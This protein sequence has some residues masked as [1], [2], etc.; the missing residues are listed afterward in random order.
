M[1]DTHCHLLPMCDDGADSWQ[2][3]LNMAREAVSIGIDTII[4]TPHHGKQ[5]YYNPPDKI[6]SAVLRCNRIFREEAI[7]L[8]VLAGQELH[9]N[10]R[11]EK[12]VD[13][14]QTLGHSGYVLLELPTKL[15]P[16]SLSKDLARLRAKGLQAIIAHPERHLPFVQ[17]P[18][19][20]YAYLR[21]GAYAQLTAAS[22]LG[23][24]GNAIQRAAWTMAR[25]GWIHLL[26]SDAHD[27]VHRPNRLG[28]AYRLAE[29][30]FG[31]RISALW[32]ANARRVTADDPLEREELS[33]RRSRTKWWNIRVF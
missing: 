28:E 6:A 31:E 5:K 11:F 23:Q 29:S 7:P 16:S 27:C 9:W 4:A 8:T 24:Q 32:A 22:L 12:A 17:H 20:L 30:E 3:T 14:L 25:N 2:T 26:A 13:G 18:E 1:I 19:K 33:P 10:G 15:T 21:E